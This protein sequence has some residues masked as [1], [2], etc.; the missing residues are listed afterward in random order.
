MQTLPRPRAFTLIELLV[1]IAIIAVLIGL[2]LPA[3]QK[4]REAAARMQC[5]NNLKQIALAAHNFEN[6]NGVLPYGR[7]RWTQTGPHVQLLPYLEQDNIFRQF[8]PRVYTLAPTSSTS[9]PIAP[10]TFGIFAFLP[11]TYAA[12]RYRVKT[13]ECPSDA[14]LNQPTY[15]VV[16]SVGQGNRDTPLPGQP[17]VPGA[18]ALLGTLANSGDVTS[19]GLPGMT[20]Y[21]ANAGTRGRWNLGGFFTSAADAYYAAHAGPFVEEERVPLIGI[22]DGTSNTIAFF[23]VT[24]EFRGS[25]YPG[26]PLGER[27]WS[28]SWFAAGSMVLGFQMPNPSLFGGSSFHGPTYNVAMCDGS[29]RGLRFVFDQP[30]SDAAV[31][32]RTNAQWDALQRLAGRSDGDVPNDLLD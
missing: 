12:A 29:V 1:V 25:R 19:Y 10:E 7:N 17:F 26:Q 6:T 30:Q 15:A 16:V 4:V 14:T 2:L 21:L 23:E 28:F 11:N 9:N 3:V 24:G 31:V 13:F 22:T 27:L 32:N 20:N 18:G 8:D 5:R